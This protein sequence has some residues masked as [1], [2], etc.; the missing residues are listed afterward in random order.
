MNSRR[1][2]I[3]FLLSLATYNAFAV[4]GR[5]ARRIGFLTTSSTSTHREEVLRSGLKD[6]GWVEGDNLQIDYRRAGNSSERLAEMAG[7]LVSNRVELIVASSTPAVVAARKAS[8]TTPIIT[9]SADPISSGFAASFRSPGGNVTGIASLAAT[10]AGKRLEL[11]K[12]ISPALNRVAFLGYEPDPGHHQF[13][14]SLGKAT[15]AMSVQIEPVLIRSVDHLQTGLQEVLNRRCRA[16]IVQSL[17]PIMGLSQDIAEFALRQRLLTCSE[18]PPFVDA[19]GLLAYGHDPS[20]TD[21]RLALYVDRILKGANPATL[22]IEIPQRFLLSLNLKSA[23]R[24]GVDV[25]MS[26]RLRAGH[27]VE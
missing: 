20:V 5:S 27:I 22:P 21:R 23:E 7:N 16:V 3:T 4:T 6:L 12:E 18:G 26:I 11:L 24:I 8:S 1:R 9:I 15:A 2:A 19:G 25:P 14:S 10:L 17:F 13:L